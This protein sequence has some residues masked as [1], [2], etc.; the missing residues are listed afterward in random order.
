MNIAVEN[1]Q[2]SHHAKTKPQA[3]KQNGHWCSRKITKTIP[4]S[5]SEKS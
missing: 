5:V 2:T 1:S 3:V 4:E